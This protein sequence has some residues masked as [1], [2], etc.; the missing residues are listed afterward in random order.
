MDVIQEMLDRLSK[1]LDASELKQLKEIK[2]DAQK[3]M[4]KI[5]QLDGDAHTLSLAQKDIVIG[6]LKAIKAVGI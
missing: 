1:E 5:A 2:K 3:L 4:Q 6:T